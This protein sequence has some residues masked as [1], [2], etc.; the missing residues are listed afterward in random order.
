MPINVQ[1]PSWKGSFKHDSA[2]QKVHK[3][4]QPL[5]WRICIFLKR[6]K[7]SI[8]LNARLHATCN[9]KRANAMSV[10]S[11]TGVHLLCFHV[12]ECQREESSRR[13]KYVKAPRMFSYIINNTIITFIS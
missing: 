3:I 9:V 1:F 11:L 12:A 4:W 8:I 6:L 13:F 2:S 5:I 7:F 10:P